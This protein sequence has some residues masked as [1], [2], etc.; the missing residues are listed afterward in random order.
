MSSTQHHEEK[1]MFMPI[2]GGLKINNKWLAQGV[3]FVTLNF[4][5]NKLHILNMRC[6][7]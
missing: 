7:L 3:Q 5:G 2:N 6:R 1:N 4:K